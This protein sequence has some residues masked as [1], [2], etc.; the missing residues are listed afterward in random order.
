M[1]KAAMNTM[2]GHYSFFLPEEVKKE[3]LRPLCAT[4]SDSE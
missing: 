3:E 2:P 1:C 4:A